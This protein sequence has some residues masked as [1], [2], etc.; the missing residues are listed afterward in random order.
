MWCVVAAKGREAAGLAG[1]GHVCWA[2]RWVE[3][4]VGQAGS[5]HAQ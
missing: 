5:R 3:A 4:L 2:G 1:G